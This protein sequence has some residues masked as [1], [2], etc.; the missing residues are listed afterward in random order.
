MNIRE[1]GF[2][3]L[4]GYLGDPDRKPLTI[5]QFRRLAKMVSAMEKPAQ[6]RNLCE[7]D[8]VSLGCAPDFAR[9]V[10]D[11]L[12]QKQLLEWYLLCGMRT[13]CVPVTRI[14]PD[15]PDRLRKTLRLD[16]PGT[17][18]LKG[19]PALLQRPSISVVGSRDL[20]TENLAFAKELGKQAALQ[21][22]TL[23]SGNARGADHAA[24]D[25]CLEHGGS[26]ISVIADSLEMLMARENVLFISEE[27]FNL[28]FSTPRALQRNRIIHS[29]S[30]KT[31]VV[32]ST[33]GKGGTWNGTCSNLQHGWSQV[34]CCD[35][36]SDAT[37][38]LECRGAVLVGT[39]ML[40]DIEQIRPNTVSF[41]D[42]I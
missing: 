11:L 18:W 21:G 10:M 22:Y 17:L 41:I 3:L 8:L 5:A 16:A 39:A 4:T 15:Y 32:Q 6:E 35:D 13:H 27:G 23:V 40:S 9:R 25:S 12:D 7:N 29:L 34:I 19:D 1:Q 26:V 2:L 33:V 30:P 31:F 36:H 28:P 42:N 38:Q 24:Q 14:S 20:R 37:R